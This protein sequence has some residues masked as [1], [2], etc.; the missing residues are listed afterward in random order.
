MKEKLSIDRQIVI[1]SVLL[2]I[3]LSVSFLF[4]NYKDKGILENIFNFVTEYL[5][6]GYLIFIFSIILLLIY[7]V[8]TKIG[9]IKLGSF[10]PEHSTLS[11][12]SMLF[13]ACIGSSILYWG[14]IE[15][16]YYFMSPPFGMK[17]MSSGAAEASVAY[18]MFHWGIS[19]WA[20]YSIAAV[21]I[22]YYFY[23][24]KIPS[25][26]ISVSCKFSDQKNESI[27]GKIVDIFIITGLVCGVAVS[28]TLGTPMISEGLK[29]LFG[30]Q[31]T[32][33]GNIMIAIFWAGLFATSAVS[34]ID[35]GIK[36]LSNI[37]SIMVVCFALFF[38][39][40]GSTTFI[41]NNTVNS[42]GYM[43]QNFIKMSFYTDPVGKS[44]FPQQWTIF[45][46]AW[47]ISY[48]PIMGL[49]IANISKGRTIRQVVVGTTVFGSMG[50]WFLQSIFGSYA[51]SLQISGQLDTVGIINKH[52]N[53]TAIMAILNTLPY[54]KIAIAVFIILSFIF[55]TTTCDSSAYILATISTRKIKIGQEPTKVS[56]LLW[57]IAIIILPVVLLI[58]GGINTVKLV[59][60]LGSVPLLII[61]LK[62]IVNFIKDVKKDINTGG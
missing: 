50:C 16:A 54:S 9:D 33:A 20:S 38:L 23:V 58:V 37:N 35:K 60:V 6:G 5:G 13:C 10:E 55:L 48:M 40:A 17:K 14:L 49:F 8:F 45:Y 4:F 12:I 57:S 18:T 62:M 2:I 42:I 53:Y 43:F 56:R 24:K 46:W 32:V 11:W 41:L 28:V 52:G 59:S 51:L 27:A 39:L 29:E 7:I 26:K 22:G 31:P 1:P 25:F 21:I 3:I 34:G 19:G 36:L 44:S 30:I 61:L 15:W 47:W